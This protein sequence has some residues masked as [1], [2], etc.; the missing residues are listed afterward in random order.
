MILT[1][2]CSKC[3]KY[4]EAEGVPTDNEL[5]ANCISISKINKSNLCKSLKLKIKNLIPLSCNFKNS[6]QN[7]TKDEKIVGKIIEFITTEE[8]IDVIAE[9]TDKETI[10]EIKGKNNG[11]N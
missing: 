9:I 5:C 3:K 1:H 11:R 10:E 6:S 8:G 4:W 7:I 2:Q